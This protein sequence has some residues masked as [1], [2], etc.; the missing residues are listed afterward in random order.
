MSKTL[1]QKQITLFAHLLRAPEDD[2]MKR[3]QYNPT[4]KEHGQD[5]GEWVDPNLNGMK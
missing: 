5:S 1:E 2:E 4:G 3:Y